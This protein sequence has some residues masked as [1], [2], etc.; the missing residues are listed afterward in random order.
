MAAPTVRREQLAQAL[1]E[2]FSNLSKREAVE[3]INYLVELIANSLQAGK[4]V[5]LPGLGTFRVREKKARVA[6]NP[7]TGEKVQVPAKKVPKFYASKDL[8]E[9]VK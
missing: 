5:K 3:I 8:K 7:K 9:L 2:K 4:Q 6:I 1:A